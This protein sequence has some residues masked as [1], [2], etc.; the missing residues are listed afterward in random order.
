VSRAAVSA[1]GGLTRALR[2][3]CPRCGV[4]GV[5]RSW[6]AIREACPA[7]GLR[8]ERGEDE[9]YWLGAYLLNFIATEVLFAVILAAVLVAT[10]PE[11]RWTML[12]WIGV[13]QMSLTPVLFYP[14]AKALWLAIDLVFRPVRPEDFG[15]PI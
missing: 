1:L 8:F 14:F 10:W 13:V 2:L 4:G 7:C 5:M 6:F 11:P 9:D 3:R 15:P 12:L